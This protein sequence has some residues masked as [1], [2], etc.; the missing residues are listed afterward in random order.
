MKLESQSFTDG[1]LIPG[2]FAFCIP[3]G[4]HHVCLG[5]NL[6]P[7]LAWS[8][9][10]VGT[11]SFALICHDLDVP[12]RG[13]DVNREGHTVPAELPRVDFFH[14]ILV[15]IPTSITSI[16]AGEFSNEVT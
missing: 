16:Q 4:T 7:H 2:Q 5:R 10:P 13:E 11:Q 9:V 1:T 15:D 6:N 3:H 14:W 12:S 8:E